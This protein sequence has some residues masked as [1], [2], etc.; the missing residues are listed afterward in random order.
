MLTNLINNAIKFTEKGEITCRIELESQTSEESVLKFSVQDTGIGIDR[1]KVRKLFRAFEQ[2]DTSTTRR[3][4]GTGLGLTISQQLVKLMRGRIGVESTE[5]RGSIFWFNGC[6]NQADIQAAELIQLDPAVLNDARILVVDDNETNR[7]ILSQQLT[8]WNLRVS[9]AESGPDALQLLYQGIAEEDPFELATIDLQ[10][11]G[12]DGET[13]GRAIK[14]VPELSR[15]AIVLLTSMGMRGDGQHFTDIGFDAYL[16]KPYL[17]DELK[18]IL[19]RIVDPASVSESQM[20]T[21]HDVPMPKQFHGHLL[22]VEDNLTNQQVARGILAKLGITLDVAHNGKLALEALNN[23]SYDLVLMDMQMPEMD[24]MEAT[25]HIR[26][27]ETMAAK[28]IPIVALTAHALAGDREKYLRSGL[29]GYVSK[30]INPDS[31]QT[32]LERFLIIS[33]N[34]QQAEEQVFSRTPLP[35]T[36]STA[37]NTQIFDRNSFHERLMGD[38]DLIQE[39]VDGFLNDMPRQLETLQDLLDHEQWVS[40]GNQAHKIKGAAANISAARMRRIASTMATAGKAEDGEAMR[41]MWS[42]LEDEA[43]LLTRQLKL[44]IV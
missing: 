3:F 21:R 38:Q 37:E 10:M 29:D 11:P 18:N 7:E 24:G 5:G 6:F 27:G 8:S 14:N 2:A 20:A 44:E 36:D 4:G 43:E 40:A 32:E 17:P 42:Q 25:R 39:V 22:L 31:L 1:D 16:T 35:S 13:L 33:E 28:D 41:Q 9:L 34:I 19:I 15:T 30:P 26:N 23:R 12:M